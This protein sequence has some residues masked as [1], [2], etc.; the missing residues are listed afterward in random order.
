VACGSLEEGDV[1]FQRRAF[2]TELRAIE[3]VEQK[4]W[5]RNGWNRNDGSGGLQAPEKDFF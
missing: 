2:R 5:K 1:R 3:L 4:R